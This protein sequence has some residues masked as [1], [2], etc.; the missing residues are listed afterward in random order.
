MFFLL[1]IFKDYTGLMRDIK[2]SHKKAQSVGS[3]SGDEASSAVLKE[4]NDDLSTMDVLEIPLGVDLSNC[5]GKNLY[6]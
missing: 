1:S 6:R 3:A 5:V 2:H 4:V